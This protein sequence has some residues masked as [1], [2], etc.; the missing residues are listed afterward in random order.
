MRKFGL[1]M[2][3]CLLLAG[4]GEQPVMETVADELL[5]V[6]EAA[7][8]QIRLELPEEAVADVWESGEGEYYRCDGYDLLLQTLPAGDLG[9]T[10]KSVSGYDMTRLTL[11]TTHP[12][13]LKRYDFV[14]SAMAQEGE[15]VARSAILDDGNYHYV[16]TVLAPASD[17]HRLEEDWEGLFQS[18]SL[19]SY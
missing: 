7:V 3:V 11:I 10:V 13:D 6:E 19:E 17:V 4:C 15:L 1:L 16:L 14:W 18:F 8:R 5:P 9:A 12:Q 2:F